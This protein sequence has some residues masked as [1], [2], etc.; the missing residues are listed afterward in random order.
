MAVLALSDLNTVIG[1]TYKLS[2]IERPL[3]KS[4][5]DIF[6]LRATAFSSPYAAAS[7]RQIPSNL[8]PNFDDVSAQL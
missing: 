7:L 8:P 4:L 2:V 5:K 1:L 6:F 3:A